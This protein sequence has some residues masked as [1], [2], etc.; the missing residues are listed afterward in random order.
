[1]KSMFLVILVSMF[2]L[3]G[4]GGSGSPESVVEEI[5][6][7]TQD[8]SLEDALDLLVVEKRTSP[9]SSLRRLAKMRDHL[10]A[11]RFSELVIKGSKEQGVSMRVF[12]KESYE[13]GKE[14]DGGAQL[15]LEDGEWKLKS[16]YVP[17]GV[18]GM[19][20]HNL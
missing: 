16:L 5:Y 17:G 9:E 14:M 8:G 6:E 12:F 20:A 1:M 7:L 19:G 18:G 4:C 10:N 2:S 3:A 11:S 13:S 15:L